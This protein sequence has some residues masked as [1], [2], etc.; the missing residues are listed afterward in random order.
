[1]GYDAAVVSAATEQ[2]KNRRERALGECRERHAAL[3]AKRPELVS[4]ENG[5]ASSGL[6]IVKALRDGRDVT[7][8]VEAIRKENLELQEMRARLLQDEGLSA[9]YLQPHFNC[10][11]CEDT[12]YVQGKVCA[13]LT[14]LLR[15]METERLGKISPLRLSSFEQFSLHYYPDEALNGGLSCRKKMEDIFSFCKDYAENFTPEAKSILMCGA[16]GLGKTHLSLAIAGTVIA[17]G[18]RVV[19]NA[20]QNLL[21]AMEQEHFGRAEQPRGTTERLLLNCDLLILDDLGAEFT[22]TFTLATL[23]NCI[24]TRLLAGRPII[25]S[26][27]LSMKQ[28]EE[29][30]TQRIASRIFTNYTLL[31]FEGRDIRQLKAMGR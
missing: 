8:A 1:M 30:Y 31:G 29:R 4:L 23:Y 14:A 3:C 24:N 21:S 7:S 28:I 2:L 15:Q 6:S 19:Y 18:Y 12:G 5:M 16:T 25:I 13:C 17:K 9:D 22:T 27:N 20:T 26:T 10:A 11:Q